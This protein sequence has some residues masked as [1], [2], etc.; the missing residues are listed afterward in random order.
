MITILFDI[1]GTLIEAGGAGMLAIGAAF[2][3]LFGIAE[4]PNIRLGGRTDQGIL[5]ELFAHHDMRY[6]DHRE[7]FDATYWQHLPHSL[8]ETEGRVLPGVVPLI[9][10]LHQRED[11]QLGILTGNSRRAAIIKLDHFQL[12]D[13]FQFGGYGDFHENRNDVARLAVNDAKLHLGDSFR[14]DRVWVVGDTVNDILCARAI[15][16]NVVA[17]QTGGVP[18]DEIQAARPDA[19]L[20]DLNDANQFLELIGINDS[21]GR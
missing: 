16:A 11:C 8:H 13:F 15:E 14:S 18:L 19:V 6:E 5:S 1:D 4:L 10:Q 2:K 7:S 9:E 20:P 12:Q 17:V 21:N 3:H